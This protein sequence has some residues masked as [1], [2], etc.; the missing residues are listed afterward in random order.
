[1]VVRL[2]AVV[3]PLTAEVERLRVL[4]TVQTFALNFPAHLIPPSAVNVAADKAWHQVGR[5]T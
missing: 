2:A 5:F 4:C 3:G 1:M